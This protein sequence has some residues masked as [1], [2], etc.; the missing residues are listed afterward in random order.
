M[1]LESNKPQ[2]SYIAT[3]ELLLN[4][5][6]FFDLIFS[7]WRIWMI[8]MMVGVVISL[9]IDLTDEKVIDYKANIV[10]NLELGGASSNSQLGG[11][12][13]AF[14]LP[15]MSG[16]GSSGELFT[17]Q[18]FPTIV[19]SRAVLER[20]LMKDVVVN[21]DTLLMMQYVMDSSDI[22]TNEWAGG[23]FSEPFTEAI[24]YKFPKKD[25]KDFTMLENVIMNSVYEKMMDVTDISV[26]KSTNSIMIITSILTN[27]LLAQKWVETVLST[28]EEFYVE[29]KTKK[30]RDMLET[31]HERLEKIQ[32]E[33]FSADSRLA[34][35]TFENPYVAD[36]SG[37]M[38]QTQISRQSSFLS[39]QYLTQ[40]TT[41]ESLNR[42]LLEET[43]IFTIMEESRLPLQ[44]ELQK[45]GLNL[46]LFGLALLFLS[47]FGIAIADT[48]RKVITS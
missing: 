43:P 34:R 11:L 9:I 29:M 14:G 36:P 8:A 21:G 37:T 22:K 32:A 27:E 28:T 48:Y 5:F 30:T 4:I 13:S 15:S 17:S 25:P 20:V 12:A 38:K 31:Q 46:K 39:T 1:S 35:I 45:S 47:I 23:L 24:N 44:Q 3:K 2:E 18:N 7:K 42:L 19:R 16:G 6:S 40:L 10:F 33:L 41:I 26:V